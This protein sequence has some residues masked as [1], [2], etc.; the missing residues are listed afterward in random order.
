MWVI[1]IIQ[2]SITIR[3]EQFVPVSKHMTGFISK[4][5]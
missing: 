2:I 5:N 4:P 1:F 3:Y